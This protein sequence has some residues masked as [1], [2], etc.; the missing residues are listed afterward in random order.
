[1]RIERPKSLTDLVTARL[2]REIEEGTFEMGEALSESRIA[3]RYEVSR[4][5]VREAFARLELEGLVRTEPQFGTFVFT[6]DRA[7]FTRISEVRSVLEVAALRFSMERG[8]AALV[9]DWR[10]ATE[11]MTAALEGADPR[12]YSAAD[13]A[14]HEA[15]FA[16]ADNHFLD[17]A[18]RSFAGRMTTIRN[19]LGATPEHMAKSW[20]EHVDLL[21]LVTAGD[22]DGA[23]ALL[24]Q[25]IRYKGASFWSVPENAPKSRWD[26]LVEG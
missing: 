19:R 25:H 4:T 18:R 3:A 8:P 11:T 13:A 5:P 26:K 12:R 1:M 10:A 17:A 21:R 15:V 2:K 20:R 24:D 14:F 22:V 6:M 23:A 7:E 9:A 16:H